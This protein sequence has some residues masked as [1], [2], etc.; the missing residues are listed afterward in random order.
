MNDS[1]DNM[2]ADLAERKFVVFAGAGIPNG[3]GKSISWM[4]LLEAFNQA[5]PSLGVP[6]VK[7]VKESE[8]D[9]YAQQVFD[10]LRCA[11]REDR[12][13]EILREKLSATNARF[14]SQQR[15]IIE[16]AQHV[17]TTNFDDSFK[18]AME[19]ELEGRKDTSIMKSL[20][21]LQLIALNANYSVSYLHGSTDEKCIVFKTEDYTTFYPSQ[22]ENNRGNDNLEQFLRHLYEERTIVFIGVSFNDKYLLNALNS[23]YNRVKQNDEV[24]REKKASYEPKLDNIKHYAFMPE[25][26]GIKAKDRGRNEKSDISEERIEKEIKKVRE[27]RRELLEKLKIKVVTYKKHLEWPEWFKELREKRRNS[28][29]R[30][31]GVFFEEPKVNGKFFLFLKNL[32]KRITKIFK[33]AR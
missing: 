21:D 31:K 33:V 4:E 28:L 29:Q 22:S 30:E 2:I 16:T 15:D 26:M 20:P 17:V 13:Y 18:N 6:N 1:A 7:E 24:A 5:E 3:D 19:R 11:Q 8:Y 12:Y 14:S 9:D 27:N 25:D 32:V 10:A 23:F